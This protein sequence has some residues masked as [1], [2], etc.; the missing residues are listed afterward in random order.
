ME[1]VTIGVVAFL[2][3]R[4]TSFL[5]AV[6]S[7]IGEEIGKGM[8][9]GDRGWRARNA[10]SVAN[11]AAECIAATGMEAQPVPGRILFPLL[12]RASVEDDATLQGKWA[13]LLASAS[14]SPDS[15]SPAFVGILSEL[16]PLEVSLLA[17]AYHH[18]L[19]ETG[20]PFIEVR[21]DSSGRRQVHEFHNDYPVAT[22]NIARLGLI[23]RRDTS[24]QQE[25]LIRVV[26]ALEQ[27]VD[28]LN[29]AGKGSGSHLPVRLSATRMMHFRRSSLKYYV[30]SSLGLAF[31]TACEPPVPSKATSPDQ[32]DSS[33]LS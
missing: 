12:E 2:T 26:K 11:Q 27:K 17:R 6:T 8:L 9:D 7:P 15:V 10:A 21:D 13:S 5:D 3:Q 25:E 24:G 18:E 32:S 29:L 19:R 1:L 20:A 33:T 30:L 23:E 31:L 4:G 16:S 28:R 22:E 14:V